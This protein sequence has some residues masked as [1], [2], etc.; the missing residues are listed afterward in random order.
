[1]WD[2]GTD[3]IDG[4]AA[5]VAD[6][7]VYFVYRGGQLVCYDQDRGHKWLQYIYPCGASSPAIGDQ[8]T[9]YLPG[10]TFGLVAVRAQ[11][12]LARSPWPKFRGNPRNTGN[13]M[14]SPR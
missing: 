7:C 8:G 13:L 1:M 5:A 12:P 4:T 2:R 10:M 11:V 3:R 14:D 9:I 6:G